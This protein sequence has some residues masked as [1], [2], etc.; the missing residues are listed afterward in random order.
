MVADQILKNALEKQ[1][2]FIGGIV[3]VFFRQTD[4]RVLN[5]IERRIIVPDGECDLPECFPFDAFEK[6]RE[7]FSGSQLEALI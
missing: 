2:Q 6:I 5:H 7:F 3:G 4:H 1:W